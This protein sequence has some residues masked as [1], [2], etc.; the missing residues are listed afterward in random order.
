MKG[1]WNKIVTWWKN[2]GFTSIAYLIL[3]VVF[4]ILG[5]KFVAGGMAGIFV[6][7]NWNV[8][9]KLPGQIVKDKQ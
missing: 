9:R 3:A 2:A 4:T 6:Y 8:I 1:I 5:N 7:V